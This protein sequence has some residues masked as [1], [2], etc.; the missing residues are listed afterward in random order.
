MGKESGKSSKWHQIHPPAAAAKSD[1][2]EAA[3]QAEPAPDETP[4]AMAAAAAAE[5]AATSSDPNAIANIVDSVL[6]DLRPEQP[7]HEAADPG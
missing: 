4:K 2:V 6:A 1:A 7:E 5:S 3:K